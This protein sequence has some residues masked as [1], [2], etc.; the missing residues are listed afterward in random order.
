MQGATNPSFLT[1]YASNA[2]LKTKAH[3]VAGKAIT[4]RPA[5]SI[6]AVETQPA[7]ECA[8]PSYEVE[9]RRCYGWFR[10]K[11]YQLLR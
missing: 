11:L 4:S 1:C 8:R 7:S 5:A 10:Y 3:V 9:S 6:I 2:Q